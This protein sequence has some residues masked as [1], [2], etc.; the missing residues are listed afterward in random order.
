MS[1]PAEIPLFP[2]NVVLFPGVLLPLHIFE[3]RYRRMLNL[4]VEEEIPFGLVL[5]TNNELPHRVG[6]AAHIQHIERL[7]DG[8][9]NIVTL[10]Q[11][12]FRVTDF[13]HDFPYLVGRV[14]EWP[15]PARPGLRLAAQVATTCQAFSAYLD[16]LRGAIGQEISVDEMPDEPDALAYLIAVALQ[17]S[18][19][20]KQ[21]LLE[22]PTL[23]E[24]L[25]Q[26]QR[27]MHS[28]TAIL[29]YMEHTRPLADDAGPISPN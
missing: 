20:Q 4:C 15:C 14:E 24:L 29:R 5:A 27:L 7:T 18:L 2:L 28:E 25:R 16:A 3:P 17:V 13:R 9:A 21:A 26:E 23:V 8:R 11:E 19:E 6:V 1:L 10:G 22:A 12:R